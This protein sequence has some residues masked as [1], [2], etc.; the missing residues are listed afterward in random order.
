LTMPIKITD[1]VSWVGV[2]DWNLR[3]FHGV[4]TPRGGTYNSYLVKDG[5]ESVLIDTAYDKFGDELVRNISEATDLKGLGHIIVNH[6]EPD[7]SSAISMVLKEAPAADVVCTARCKDFLEHQG[8]NAKFQVVKEGDM[9]R[10]GSRT[11]SFI[12]APM[13]HW[14]EVMWTF[15]EEERVLFPCDMFGA[16]VIQSNLDAEEV[17]DIEQHIKRYF[18]F[19]FRPLS[20]A[21][22]KGLDKA[23]RLRPSV[24]CPSHGPI[25]RDASRIQEIYRLLA[26]AP[27]KEKALIAYASIWGDVERMAKAIAEGVQSTG[28]EVVLKDVGELTWQGWSDLLADAMEAKGIAV[29]SPTVL[30]GIFP[31]LNYATMLMRLVKAKG[32]VGVSFGTYG[33]GPGITKKL[34]DELAAMDAKPYRG[35]LEVRFKPTERDLELCRDAGRELGERIRGVRL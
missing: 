14:P 24:I 26:T 3:N 16:Q 9:L 22:I 13:L 2:F 12:E 4:W 11:L 20:S 19:I 31:Q 34:D 15:L 23:E 35:G 32:K 17:P 25:W 7:H 10:V 27:E 28:V 33:W 30:G 1:S 21:V 18:A 29:G 5:G 8:V 6:A